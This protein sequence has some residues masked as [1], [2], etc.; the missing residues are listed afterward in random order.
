MRSIKI[1][2]ALEACFVGRAQALAPLPHSLSP[3]GD[4]PGL[5]A[6]LH[7]C[8]AL[9]EVRASSQALGCMNEPAAIG[10]LNRVTQFGL[11]GLQIFKAKATALGLHIVNHGPRDFTFVKIARAVLCQSFKRRRQPRLVEPL[12]RKRSPSCNRWPLPVFE[13]KSGGISVLCKIAGG[14]G[15]HE[16]G[17]PVDQHAVFCQSHRRVSKVLSS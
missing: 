1:A 7:Q 14:G 17:V 5:N 8:Q 4:W 12:C 15:D 16:R 10:D 13:K 11:V 9:R 6:L 3:S 2:H